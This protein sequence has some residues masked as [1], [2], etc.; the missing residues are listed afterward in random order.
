MPPKTS[1]VPESTIR[2]TPL[3]NHGV[4][5]SL[6]SHS[7]VI[8]ATRSSLTKAA[9]VI[10]KELY[11]CSLDGQVAQG[12]YHLV[13]NDDPE[14]GMMFAWGNSYN[15][16]HRFKCA[17]GA[18][19]YVCD[20]GM[21]NGDAA[22]YSRIHKGAT[23]LTEA[24]NSID[25]QIQSASGHFAQLIADKEALKT[26]L[27]NRRDQSSILGQL[28]AVED[29]ITLHQVGMI[30]KEMDQSSYDYSTERETVD[31]N[32]AWAMY[33]HV[34]NALKESHP[35]NY[36]KDHQLVHDFFVKNFITKT[37]DGYD[38]KT[39]LTEPVLS[40]DDAHILQKEISFENLEFQDETPNVSPTKVFG[41]NFS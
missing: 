3:P 37:A 18:R 36:L 29:A 35:A 10:D 16:I 31:F 38:N 27:L 17:V 19:V 33:N 13:S 30:K 28:Y 23:A 6:I 39:E 24:L 14:I 34:T 11:K 26:V 41:V 25:N 9:L 40:F 8:D 2:N 15:K 7:L 1:Y 5:Y 32:S 21:I 12:I 20:N 22:S 4:K